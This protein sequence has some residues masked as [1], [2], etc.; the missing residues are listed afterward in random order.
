MLTHP[1]DSLPHLACPMDEDAIPPNPFCS[2][3]P[4]S[5]PPPPLLSLSSTTPSLSDDGI[6][7][8]RRSSRIEGVQA[9][10]PEKHS[11]ADSP[12]ASRPSRHTP[13]PAKKQRQS[14]EMVQQ[15]QSKQPRVDGVHTHKDQN[16][17]GCDV[18]FTA[19]HQYTQNNK[20]TPPEKISASAKQNVEENFSLGANAALVATRSNMDACDQFAVGPHVE[21]GPL[22]AGWLIGPLFQSFK[23]K[24][25]SFTEIVMS[26]V[27]L[28]KGT[29]PLPSVGE[30]DDG[31]IIYPETQS[32]NGCQ[33]D[34]AHRQK[35]SEIRHAYSKTINFDV[36]M[37][38]YS[39]EQENISAVN[40]K[41]ESSP[42]LVPL[43][44]RPLSCVV[45]DTPRFVPS[46]TTS[47]HPVS[48]S[49]SLTSSI[50]QDQNDQHSTR[51]EPLPQHL[52]RN[53][54][55]IKENHV[56]KCLTSDG[57]DAS[58]SEVSEENLCPSVKTNTG[59][60]EAKEMS[61]FLVSYT[62]PDP[63]FLPAPAAHAEKF[64]L[65]RQ[66]LYNNHRHG[67]N[68][69][70]KTAPQS[71]TSGSHPEALSGT[72]RTKRAH[73]LDGQSQNSFKKKRLQADS[74]AQDTGTQESMNKPS[75]STV[76]VLRSPR[77]RVVLT[78]TVTD[79]QETLK[80]ARNRQVGSTG[81]NRKVKGVKVTL[82]TVA[83]ALLDMQTEGTPT[84]Q[85]SGFSDTCSAADHGDSSKRLKT[86]ALAARPEGSSP[87][88]APETTVAMSSPQEAE[89][90]QI[91][92]V[93]I[94][95]NIK[96][97]NRKNQRSNITSRPP[98]RK[99]PNQ[100]ISQSDSSSME[101]S[102]SPSLSLVLHR[103]SPIDFNSHS[104]AEQSQPPKRS[105]RGCQG[106]NNSS[107]SN[108]THE[109]TQGTNALLFITK[110]SQS[111][112]GERSPDPLGRNFQTV[113]L[114]EPSPDLFVQLNEE[115]QLVMNDKVTSSLAADSDDFSNSS[116]GRPPSLSRNVNVK[117][118]RAEAERRR[119]RILLSRTQGEDGM[120]SATMEDADLP[121]S[122]CWTNGFTGY[123]LRSSSCP[124]IPSLHSHDASW[125]A[126][127]HTPHHS[128]N[129]PHHHSHSNKH[130]RRTR[131]HTVCSVEVE[132]EIA[133][134]CLRKEVYPSRRM[135]S[136]SDQHS[137]TLS[138]SSSF[139]A[140]ASC[141]L[142]S[143]LAF[144][145]KK[146]DG[147]GVTVATSSHTPASTSVTSPLSSSGWHHTHPDSSGALPD[148][149]S[150]G[151]SLEGGGRSEED[152][153]GEDTSSSSQEFEDVGLREEKALSDSE[154]KVVQ[155]LEEPGKV[156]SIRIRKTLP[157]PQNNLTPMGLP[158]PIRLK[159]KQFSLE[160]IYTNKNFSK[161]PESRLETIFEVPLNRKNG[162]ES[163]FG[164]RRLK[165]FLKFLDGGEPRKPKKPLPGSGKAG[166]SSSSFT[167][168]PRR[169]GFAK[170]EP[171]LSVPDVDSLLSA[172]LDQ[173]NL[174]LI[175]D[176][177]DS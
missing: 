162:S 37:A 12:E 82:T 166:G 143:P 118:R 39:S 50:T 144:L 30:D 61:P 151:T 128:R 108:G 70:L 21:S 57:K 42:D 171:S 95:P 110:E 149:S 16:Q 15:S 163:W 160:E 64:P 91:A 72:G 67:G 122:S 81:R 62:Q 85:G 66:S 47:D 116:G 132:R 3:P 135:G 32:E 150:S 2:A 100:K 45:S 105:K 40:R 104:T 19:Q 6:S 97:Q 109:A 74:V 169:G 102:T 114:Y 34:E 29:D 92:E 33:G 13:S 71:L 176:Q 139:L 31:S 123:L 9:Q 35:L 124:E 121:R 161:P 68:R 145:S 156:S 117:P 138:P 152:D 112:E 65:V 14:G 25:A 51:V 7:G 60:S 146:A 78:D 84:A 53:V 133:P 69:T 41:E 126:P 28:L 141:F 5:D 44:C 155:K 55:E 131:R 98:K 87:S 113:C 115:D 63:V 94:R 38:K 49:A 80:P 153:D 165:R 134:L 101:P 137:A 73:K 36:E 88:M 23:T 142:S 83:D 99:S 177:M 1:S 164:Q 157:K 59:L 106:A 11:D 86:R 170:E 27:K 168:R 136:S 48:Q 174:W 58:N 103:L 130:Q 18:D 56:T 20:K 90:E 120:K 79:H 77:K 111:E 158:K 172:K 76:R 4:H 148:T 22:P 43:P 175:H 24:M 140:L 75:S 107:L 17:D 147:R 125:A 54:P 89:A 167:S 96:Q 173:L 26:P 127:L 10:T 46:T 154:I 129:H 8:H 159:K 52:D 119:C 93:L